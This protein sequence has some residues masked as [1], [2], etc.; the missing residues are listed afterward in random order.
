VALLERF[1]REGNS[2]LLATSSFW[3]GV[4]VPGRSLEQLII[5]KLPFPVPR[6]PVVEAHC[7]RLEEAGENPFNDYMVPRTAIKLRQGFGRLIRS[8]T[9]YGAVV[10]LDS[11][12]ASRRYGARL[13]SELPTNVLIARSDAELLSALAGVHA[14]HGG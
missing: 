3:E 4:D 5:V 8:T 10:F 12:L 2:V 13:L 11:R 7:E 1:A 6:D 9:D 14:G